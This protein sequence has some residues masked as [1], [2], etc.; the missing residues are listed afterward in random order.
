MTCLNGVESLNG[1]ES[2]DESEKFVGRL[3]S[4]VDDEINNY[5]NIVWSM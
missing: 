1:I 4:Y 5:L 2:N 3:L